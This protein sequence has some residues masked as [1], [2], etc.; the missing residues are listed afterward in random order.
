MSSHALLSASSSHRWLSCTKSA[1]LEEGMN[2]ETSTAAL[3]GTDAHEI[4]EYKLKRALGLEVNNPVENLTYYSSEMEGYAD[5]YVTYV[6]ERYE[7]AK[8]RCKDPLILIE[9]KLDFSK[10]VPEGFGTGDCVIIADND[11]EIIDFKYGIGV[12]V[13]ACENSQMKLYALGA[14]ARYEDLY[15]IKNVRMSIFQPRRDN[16]SVFEIKASELIAWAETELKEK[17]ELA[18]KGEGDFNAGEHCRFCKA[19]VKCRARAEENLKI[20]Q[21][22]FKKPELLDDEEIA[23]ILKVIPDLT[24]WAGEVQSYATDMAVSKGKHWPGFKL[25]EGRSNRKY[26]DEEKVAEVLKKNGYEDIY[27]QKLF[28]LTEVEKLLGKVK[29]NE[30]LSGLIHKPKGKLTLV[31]SSDKRQEVIVTNATEEFKKIGGN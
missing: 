4:S 29:F 17:S 25:I 16:L 12:V 28:T 5:D 6:L 9:E 13:D 27:H 24:K 20:A 14:L 8:E 23:E 31:P 3:E 10:Y 15:D 1:R 11:I 22:E 2:D 21:L 30:L 18:F 26:K 19:A 7:K